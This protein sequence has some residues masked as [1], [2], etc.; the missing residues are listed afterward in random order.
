[1]RLFSVLLW[2]GIIVGYATGFFEAT[3]SDAVIL[4]FFLLLDSLVEFDS[5]KSNK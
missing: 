3:K 4:S 5:N 1:M 2:V